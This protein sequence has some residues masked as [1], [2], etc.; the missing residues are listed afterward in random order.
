MI[1]G[2]HFKES[3]YV[4]GRKILKKEAVP[5]MNGCLTIKDLLYKEN[6]QLK[7]ELKYAKNRLY[8]DSKKLQTM[9]NVLDR[10]KSENFIDERIHD[11]LST[12]FEGLSLDLIK[13]LLKNQ[14]RQPKG[15]RYDPE[16]KMFANTVY[17]YSPR[18]YA[19]LQPILGLP[20]AK[21]VQ[22]WSQSVDAEP[23]YLKTVLDLLKQELAKSPNK[24]HINV[25]IDEMHLHADTPYNQSTQTFEGQID[26]GN[27]KDEMGELATHALVVMAVGVTARFKYPIAYFLTG[28]VDAEKLADIIEHSIRLL[29]DIGANVSSV[30][31][32]GVKANWSAMK[33]LGCDLCFTRLKPYFPH[34]VFPERKIYYIPDVVHMVKLLRNLFSDL[35]VLKVKG[36]DNK[37]EWRFVEEMLKI[38]QE[39]GVRCGNKLNNNHIDWQD[40]KMKFSYAKQVLNASSADSIDY[41]REDIGLKQFQNSEETSKFM[42]HVDRIFHRLNSLSPQDTGLRAPIRKENYALVSYTL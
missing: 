9:N 31:A 11:L 38:Q 28:S 18:A 2:E 24:R 5:D 35:K 13:N 26:Y 12:K 1:C 32:D 3:D 39:E 21:T 34:P 36:S 27:G 30:T 29:T 10:L 6:S 33:I 40:H 14:N 7:K 16:I 17:F 37:I 8:K 22:S 20:H 25:V 15:K 41:A 19:Y 42:R 23:G 4:E